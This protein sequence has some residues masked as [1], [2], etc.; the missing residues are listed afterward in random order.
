ML[1]LQLAR[2][3]I[4]ALNNQL[5]QHFSRTRSRIHQL[6]ILCLPFY[7]RYPKRAQ[8][9]IQDYSPLRHYSGLSRSKKCSKSHA[10]N[11]KRPSVP[12]SLEE[13]YDFVL[14]RLVESHLPA[15]TEFLDKA[16]SST[17][18]DSDSAIDFLDSL[19]NDGHDVSNTIK[20]LGR[21]QNIHYQEVKA[22]RSHFERYMTPVS[23]YHWFLKYLYPSE[24]SIR[25]GKLY[26]GYQALPTPRPLHISPQHLEDLISAFMDTRKPSHRAIY[27]LLIEDIVDC[28]MPIS[29]H[30]Y[31][32]ATFMAIT[33]FFEEVRENQT[34]SLAL[35]Q[36]ERL[37]NS[38]IE[39]NQ[40]DS[41]T[42]NILYGFALKSG[43][44]DALT[45]T[46]REFQTTNIHPDR[47]T[48]IIY[49]LN[50]GVKGDH[51]A[52]RRIYQEMCAN[53]YVI[54]ISTIN[55]LIKSMLLCGDIEGAENVYLSIT[56]QQ[57]NP[58][59]ASLKSPLAYILPS[60]VLVKKV[61]LIDLTVRILQENGIP[62]DSKNLAVPIVP[63]EF[64]FGAMLSHYCLKDGDFSKSMEVLEVMKRFGIQPG[65]RQFS[66]L[67]DG[68]TINSRVKALWNRTTLNQVTR[69]ICLRYEDYMSVK[70][71][72]KSQL[73]SLFDKVLVKKVFK[74]YHS[75]YWDFPKQVSEI[76]DE[77]NPSAPKNNEN[78]ANNYK[79]TPHTVYR[80]LTKLMAIGQ[81]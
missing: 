67:Y 51:D 54:E 47:L 17:T 35:E 39:T 78:M 38:I 9:Q 26:E 63:D 73:Y 15:I 43:Q 42:L 61:K 14:T 59:I 48:M 46:M 50:A 6:S 33:S 76:Q 11:D 79:P 56:Q 72:S 75:V 70:K 31:N 20:R 53:G 22:A 49:L 5:R 81:S 57:Q 41:S 62:V 77:L 10:K 37:Q 13:E 34:G 55:V 36:I 45:Q 65:F 64:T 29:V 18:S 52:V 71:S 24:G 28:G 40:K 1:P 58:S 8:L 7:S 21:L 23:D 30:E 2:R 69:I 12:H 80:A 60:N 3:Q 32:A 68:F 66:K 19:T 25:H 74:A 44:D 16:E 27:N 4:P